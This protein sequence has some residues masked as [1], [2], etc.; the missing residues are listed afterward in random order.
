MRFTLGCFFPLCP[1][2]KNSCLSASYTLTYLLVSLCE[3][4]N[5]ADFL[6]KNKHTCS[7]TAS[8]TPF[9]LNSQSTDNYN[10]LMHVVALYNAEKLIIRYLGCFTDLKWTLSVFIYAQ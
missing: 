6:G 3:K 9:L 7:A 10:N 2:D 4:I 5:T 8:K 1:G